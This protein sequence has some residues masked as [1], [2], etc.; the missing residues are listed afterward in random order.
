MKDRET[1]GSEYFCGTEKSMEDLTTSF[2]KNC[3]EPFNEELLDDTA[4][5]I[6]KYVDNCILEELEKKLGKVAERPKAAPC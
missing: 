4:F 2:Q 3:L 5:A 1:S 6:R